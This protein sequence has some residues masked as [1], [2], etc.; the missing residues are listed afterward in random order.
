VRDRIVKLAVKYAGLVGY[1]IFYVACLC[2]F[3]SLTFPYDKLKERVIASFNAQQRSASA[4]EELQIDEMNGYWLSGVRLKGLR[5]LSAPSEAG[6][7]PGMI[8]LDE[9]TARYSILSALVGGSDAS[10]DVFAFGGQASGSYEVQGTDKSIDVTF[11]AIDLGQVDPIVQLL[12]VPLQGKLG[13]TL[14]LAMPEGKASKAGGA[15][16]LE[17][18]DVAVGD[19]KAKIKGA[20]A[21]P[22]V[23]VGT[24]TLAAEAKEGIL[25]ITKLVAGGKDVEVQGEG[26]I[27]LRD[28]VSESLCDAQVRFKINDAYRD[29]SDMTKTLFGAPGSS[30]PALFE[31]ADPRVKQSRR[32]DGFYGWALRGALGRIEFSPAGGGV[33]ANPPSAFGPPRITQ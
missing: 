4:P 10:F 26:R 24:L 7:P 15:I 19:G 29:K 2:V 5:L 1:P 13:G 3:G 11:D 18:R 22:R 27:T 12:G 28:S 20:L 32:V 6:K 9:V 17:A 30:A 25:R 21:L 14:R 33:L 23:D 16:S 8:V 31:L